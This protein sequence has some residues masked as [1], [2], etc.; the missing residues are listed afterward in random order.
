M[1]A[2]TSQA[3]VR[4]MD[5]Y[6]AGQ[7]HPPSGGDRLAPWTWAHPSKLVSSTGAV[8]CRLRVCSM[9]RFPRVSEGR[10]RLLR[11]LL[12]AAHRTLRESYSA[13]LHEKTA[14]FQHVEPKITCLSRAPGEDGPARDDSADAQHEAGFR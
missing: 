5:I 8:C 12:L 7:I 10:T 11:L 1:G 9:C 6:V 4:L 14:R 3:R 13:Q 2:A